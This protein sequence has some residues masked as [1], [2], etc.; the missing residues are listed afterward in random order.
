[1]KTISLINMKGGV[2][3]TTLATNICDCLSRRHNKKVLLVDIDPQFNA[4]QCLFTGE[5]YIEHLKSEKDTIINIF[6]DRVRNVASSVNGITEKKSKD[7]NQIRPFAFKK[8]FHLMPGNLDLYRIEMSAG[9]GKEYRLK[10]YIEEIQKIENY[11]FIIIDTPPTPSIFMTSA[12]LASNYYLL[13]V[14]PDPL[15]FTGIDL[16][17]AI[18]ED[19][20][21]NLDLSIECIGLVFTMVEQENSIVYRNAKKHVNSSSRKAYLYQKY[22]PKRTDIAKYQL[23]KSFMLDLQD[24]ETALSLTNI[25]EEL[26]SRI[27]KNG[28]V[29]KK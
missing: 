28:Q 12:L 16:L 20:S 1:M 29:K 4:T 25:V 23:N 9:S 13:P 2:G 6:E 19:K 7:L 11:D 24:S 27:E 3:K 15:S 8:N 26:L 18:I 22:I 21:E 17:K 5:E 14:K 10:K